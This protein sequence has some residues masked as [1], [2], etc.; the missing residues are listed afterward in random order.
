MLLENNEI[1]S[2]IFVGCEC[3]ILNWIELFLYELK[4][5]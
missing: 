4:F 5:I 1:F 3:C 2:V